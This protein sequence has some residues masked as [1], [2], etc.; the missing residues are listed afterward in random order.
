MALGWLSRRE[1][2]ERQVRQRLAR[3]AVSPGEIEAAV[4]R[5][6]RERAL[7]DQRVA[8]AFLRTAVRLK[9]RGPA[10][11]RIDLYALGIDRHLADAALAEAFA[12]TDEASVLHQALR[13]RWRL[14]EAP[15]PADAARLFRALM[16]QGFASDKIRAALRTLGTDIED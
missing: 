12:E 14:P 8:G 9:A 1:L 6:K 16:R 13:K 7:D 11:L 4:V 3:R 5:L 2:S 10:R 15:S